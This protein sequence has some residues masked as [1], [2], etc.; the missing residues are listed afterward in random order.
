MISQVVLNLLTKVI[1]LRTLMLVLTTKYTLNYILLLP[2][3]FIGVAPI[4]VL[5]PVSIRASGIIRPL[6]IAG[7]L[8]GAYSPGEPNAISRRYNRFDYAP[9]AA[10]LAAPS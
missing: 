6:S 9:T 8:P 7:G 1:A 2:S 10:L 5:V 3:S 4:G